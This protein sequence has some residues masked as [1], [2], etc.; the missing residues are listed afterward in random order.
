MSIQSEGDRLA[1]LRDEA[2][3][4]L[5]VLGADMPLAKTMANLPAT[6]NTIGF[7]INFLAGWVPTYPDLEYLDDLEQGKA[8]LVTDENMLYIWSGDAFPP[9]GEGLDPRGFTGEQGP[10]GLQGIQGEQGIQGVKGDPGDAGRQIPAIQITPQGWPT[11]SVTLERTGSTV[12]MIGDSGSTVLAANLTAVGAIPVGYRPRSLRK[13][14]S[15]VLSG[16]NNSVFITI[17]QNG[18]IVASVGGYTSRVM[19]SFMWSTA[20]PYP[21]EV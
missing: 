2:Y 15:G 13:F 6:I 11:L 14:N 19:N 17:D 9:Q 18:T 16:N 3:Q 20:D 21:D 10:Q 4:I 8:Y 12:E 1:G 5:E 7:W